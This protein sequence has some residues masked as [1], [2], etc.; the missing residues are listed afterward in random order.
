MILE[1]DTQVDSYLKN[2][3][4]FR[5]SSNAHEFTIRY[6]MSN[7]IDGNFPHVGISA[8][9]GFNILYKKDNKWFN[10]DLYTRESPKVINMS[11][12]IKN[13]DEDY[14]IL[15]YGPLLST[16][17]H[18]SIEVQDS[19]N[20]NF[21]D[22]DE[23]QKVLIVGG[24]HSFGIGCTSQ[25]VMFSNIL[26]RKFDFEINNL[27][28]N[29]RNYLK[30]V[31]LFLENDSSLP[32]YEYIILELDYF[33]Q[34]DDIVSDYLLKIIE[35]L[36]NHCNF[37]IGWSSISFNK[38]YKIKNLNKLLYD[39]KYDER[40]VICDFSDLFNKNN[41][42]QCAS[43]SYFINDT[44]NIFLYKKLSKIIRGIENGIFEFD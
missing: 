21:I 41:I 23:K 19:N 28:F 12:M 13:F 27:T 3:P 17:N 38:S 14:E 22:V 30:D 43:S 1:F 42:D 33:N 5:F 6:E 29:N 16:V 32:F 25:G 18:F 35:K 10:V 36:L 34:D 40:I 39:N 2:P 20:I 9:Q 8:R 15:I 26:G 4:Y 31:S 7:I 44:G 24:V 37:L 11:K